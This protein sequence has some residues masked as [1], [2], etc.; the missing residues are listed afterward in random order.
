MPWYEPLEARY[1][2]PLKTGGEIQF[3][4]GRRNGQIVGTS[5]AYVKVVGRTDFKEVWFMLESSGI[6]LRNTVEQ[7]T[8]EEEKE[9]L[10]KLQE[11]SELLA[12]RMEQP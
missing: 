10:K 4:W 6:I 1:T 5:P 8:I 3:N 11:A 9:L 2:F 7:G 12:R